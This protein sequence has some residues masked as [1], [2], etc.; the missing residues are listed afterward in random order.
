MN[1][2]RVKYNRRFWWCRQ[3]NHGPKLKRC[4]GI[5]LGQLRDEYKK[6]ENV[7][8]K[9]SIAAKGCDPA[10]MKIV[11]AQVR[12][13]AGKVANRL[14]DLDVQF[15]LIK[16]AKRKVKHLESGKLYTGD[17]KFIGDVTGL[18]VNLRS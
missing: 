16:A 18:E 5:T 8:T 15:S 9:R 13:R 10:T 14:I 7:L 17:G 3:N 2:T 12:G 11:S 6:H 4:G 1:K